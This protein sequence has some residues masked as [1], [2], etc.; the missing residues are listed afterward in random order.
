MLFTRFA[1][2]DLADFNPNLNE[3][4]E[5]ESK[6]E[7]VVFQSYEAYEYNSHGMN[8]NYRFILV[9]QDFSSALKRG[10][11]DTYG[12]SLLIVPVKE[13]LS[14]KMLGDVAQHVGI[15]QSSVKAL[16]MLSYGVAA[17]V[18]YTQGL[19]KEAGDKEFKGFKRAE[20]YDVV[21]LISNTLKQ[22]NENINSYLFET[23]NS[24]SRLR[25][26]DI[27][28]FSVKSKEMGKV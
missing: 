20:L 25:Y 26:I 14:P 6:S 15:N 7:R 12:A 28:R 27:M 22:I 4:S 3:F 21:A 18:G 17:Y 2:V 16:D 13:C 23:V 19:G 11:E 5:I 1:G 8:F 10:R 9:I 24:D